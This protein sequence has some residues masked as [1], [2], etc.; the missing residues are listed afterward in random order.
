MG[1]TYNSNNASRG[2][3]MR[4]KT[5]F[6]FLVPVDEYEE[7]R[8][9]SYKLGTSRGEL[10]RRAVSLF[11]KKYRKKDKLPESSKCH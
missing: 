4:Y 1:K 10:V 5:G 6:H 3:P 11:L 2:H 8:D 9:L 7:L